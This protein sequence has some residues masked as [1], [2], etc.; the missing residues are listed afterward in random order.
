MYI[1]AYETITLLNAADTV[2]S[3]YNVK[4]TN[5]SLFQLVP[6]HLLAIVALK[7]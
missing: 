4:L 1:Y 6:L 7:K 3:N 2:K 5:C